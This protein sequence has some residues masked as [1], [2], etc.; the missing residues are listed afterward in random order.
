MKLQKIILFICLLVF[1]ST[2]ANAQVVTES[3]ARAALQKRGISESELRTALLAKGIDLDKIDPTNAAELQRVQRII[4]E[5]VTELE[6]QKADGGTPSTED[7]NVAKEGTIENPTQPVNSTV[8]TPVSPIVEAP[9]TESDKA[10]VTYPIYG[11]SVFSGGNMKVFNKVEDGRATGSYVLGPGDVVSI[12][13]WGASVL[14]TSQTIGKEGF[15]Q[16][17]GMPR[18]YLSGLTVA[19]AEKLTKSAYAQRS[20]F[21]SQDFSFTVVSPRNINVNIYGEVKVNGTFYLSALNSAFNALVATGGLTELASV[22]K[23]TLQRANQKPKR[24]DV[25]E[26]LSNPIIANDFS[27]QENDFIHVPAAEKLVTITGAVLRNG[28]Y[29]LLPEEKLGAL[30]KFAGGTKANALLSAIQLKRI[31]NNAERIIDINYEE[32]LSN[33]SDLSLLNGDQI[34]IKT[35]EVPVENTVN[36]EGAVYYPDQ[37]AIT[38]GTR[39][40][41]ILKRA[42]PRENAIK[43][44]VYLRRRNADKVTVRYELINA[45]AALDNPGGP[46]DIVLQNGDVLI[47]R[48]AADF[49]ESG[50]ASISGAVKSEGSFVVNND[51]NFTLKDALFISGGLSENAT[52]FGYITRT[53]PENKNDISYLYID[54]SKEETM[55]TKV[56]A[57]DII[58]IYTK[59]EFSEQTKVQISGAVRS[60]NSYAYHPNLTLKDLIILSGGLRIDAAPNRVDVFRLRFNQGETTKTIATTVDLKSMN[61]FDSDLDFKLEPYDIV[62]VRQV[63]EFSL[64]KSVTIDGE[65]KYPGVYASLQKESRISGMIKQ[66]GGLNTTAYPEG[67]TLFREGIG[68]IVLELKDALSNPGGPSDFILESG[69]IIKVPELNSLVTI[70]GAVELDEVAAD[71][72]L[73]Q[74]KLYV[75]YQGDKRANYY[76]NEFA[77]GFKDKALRKKVTVQYQNGRVQKTRNF[78][79]FKVYPKVLPGSTVSVPYEEVKP[80]T[81]KIEGEKKDIDWGEVLASA[82]SQ[83]TA[84]LSL[85]LLLRAISN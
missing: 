75:S 21:N 73:T 14:N 30:I 7:A 58:K 78:G 9:V 1:V 12:S 82:V 69:D 17:Q 6:K 27:L 54:L 49:A 52:N 26:F 11:Q 15:I 23:I 65:V 84:V 19:D 81:Q 66:A 80:E 53:N 29:E 46:D 10:P 85:I 37:F 13:I 39:L 70:K 24:L 31:E 40:T 45:A 60:P 32:L 59:E 83:A 76:I 51:D 22:R 2:Q 63:P 4:E 41:E 64:Q 20:I 35:I 56:N 25:Y 61:I 47:I 72:V 77:G 33:K 48:S 44:I 62:V 16:P 8:A 67:A 79:L 74:G 55:Y 68:Y 18:L 3:Q 42:Q 71:F 57:G 28:T 36:V 43:D 5:T 34:S 38:P 50:Q